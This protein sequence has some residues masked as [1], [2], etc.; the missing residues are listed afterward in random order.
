MVIATDLTR[1]G[2]LKTKQKID[3]KLILKILNRVDIEGYTWT[4]KVFSDE[5]TSTDRVHAAKHLEY[6]EKA[7]LLEF[8]VIPRYLKQPKGS[9]PRKKTYCMTKK[10]K[11]FLEKNREKE[12]ELISLLA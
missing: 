1:L 9:N 5:A 2:L 7:G 10:G 4:D 6:M 3:V 11:I 8:G 12:K